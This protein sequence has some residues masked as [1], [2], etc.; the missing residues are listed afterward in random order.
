MTSYSRDVVAYGVAMRLKAQ[1]DKPRSLVGYATV[2]TQVL[3]DA[4][5]EIQKYRELIRRSNA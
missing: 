5:D 1:I 3:Q 2:P 4:L